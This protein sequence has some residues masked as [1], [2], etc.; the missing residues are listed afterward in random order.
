MN[1]LKNILT[2]FFKHY[3]R[4]TE[5]LWSG[6]F[7]HFTL[8]FLACGPFA[9]TIF[10]LNIGQLYL[11]HNFPYSVFTTFIESKCEI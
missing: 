7:L 10:L 9:C 4:I 6:S 11:Y 5:G 2:L 3:F 8:K 1:F